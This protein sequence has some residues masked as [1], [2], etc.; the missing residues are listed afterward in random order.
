M[1]IALVAAGVAA[2]LLGWAVMVFNRLVRRRNQ[3]RSAW[4]DVDVQL[5][6]RHDLVPALAR[7]VSAYADHE[8][9]TLEAV[10][11]LRDRAHGL[12]EPAALAAIEP[13]LSAGIGRLLALREAYPD[14][15]ASANFLQLQ[16]DL[17]EVEANL[18]YARR[19]YNGA[20]RELND[21]VQRVPDLVVARIAGIGPAPFF[22]AEPGERAAM[23]V[24]L[25]E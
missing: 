17:V 22:E 9:G 6:R 20:V 18:Q 2:L 3:V 16:R 10:T 11:A 4:A 24:H 7:A 14:L 21:A 25:A 15:A 5:M 23:P 8:R 19:F 13:A 12:H 1:S